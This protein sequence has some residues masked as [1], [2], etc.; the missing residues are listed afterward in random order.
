MHVLCESLEACNSGA[1]FRTEM[2]SSAPCSHIDIQ[3]HA[4]VAAHSFA[5]RDPQRL[6]TLE[7]QNIGLPYLSFDLLLLGVH[8]LLEPMCELIVLCLGSTL[9]PLD[10][11]EEVCGNLYPCN[12]KY[13]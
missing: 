6:A 1:R 9:P 8:A 3:L 7:A 5:R 2:L 4:F 11:L 12:I 13:E 10:S